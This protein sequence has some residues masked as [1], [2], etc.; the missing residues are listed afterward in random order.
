MSGIS[1]I[2]IAAAIC[3]LI[4]LIIYSICIKKKNV[5]FWVLFSCICVVNV[6]YFALS[7]SKTLG[8]ALMANRV[9]YLGS[10]FL[11][12][13]MLMIVLNASGLKYHKLL[14]VPLVCLGVAVFF[15]AASPGYLGIYYRDV[16]LVTKNGV[17][18][19]NKEYGSWHVLYLF[20]LIGY[21]VT[22]IAAVIHAT[23]KKKI[24]STAQ[25][26]M[27]L[28]AVFVN[29]CVWLI[30]QFIKIELEF[31]AISYIMTELFLIGVYIMIQEN[32][33]RIALA[34]EHFVAQNNIQESSINNAE[35]SDQ[36][37][38]LFKQGITTLTQTE[39]LVYD[40]YIDGKSTKEVLEQMNIKENT[41][42]YHNKNIY[43]KLGVPSRKVLKEIAKTIEKQKI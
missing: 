24:A 5:W 21:F 27:L 12:V 41:L 35:Y 25:A 17:S 9:A 30:E 29:I 19:L 40:L 31:L 20:Y 14:W 36:T 28:S 23:V 39:K 43:G 22:M 10:V 2:Y 26:I 1:I 7:I 3:S 8:S 34:K 33:K 6:G 18:V 32:E 16:E 37:I 13:A 15:V 38:K 4:L 11:P 42:K